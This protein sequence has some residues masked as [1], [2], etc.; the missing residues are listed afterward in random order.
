M[1]KNWKGG[2]L[3]ADTIIESVMEFISENAYHIEKSQAYQHLGASVRTVE[4]IRRKDSNLLFVEAKTTFPNP[5]NPKR[6]EEEID[7]ICDKYIHSL[8]LFSSIKVG[9]TD[10]VLPDIFSLLERQ[11]LVFILVVRDHQPDW[12]RFI[13][14]K[15][16]ENFPPYI[17]KIWKPEIKV[18]NMDLAKKYCLVY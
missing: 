9:I 16:S 3:V 8:N 11:T 4:F 14:N 10:D 1:K 13:K 12:C 15:I 6:F 2:L 17:K 7:I 5:E 18:Y